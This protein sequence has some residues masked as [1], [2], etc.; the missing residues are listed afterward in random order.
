MG[1]GINAGT[2]LYLKQDFGQPHRSKISGVRRLRP[3]LVVCTCTGGKRFE[4]RR[5][6]FQKK[7]IR[8]VAGP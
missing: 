3:I 7:I 5:S 2:I 4:R 6:K 8:L 1:D